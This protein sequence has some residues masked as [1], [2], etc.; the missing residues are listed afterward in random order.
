MPS[1]LSRNIRVSLLSFHDEYEKISAPR[2]VKE[3]RKNLDAYADLEH[4]PDRQQAVA[5]RILDQTNRINESKHIKA[6]TI[7]SLG[8]G[9][10]QAAVL[11]AG[12]LPNFD[13]SAAGVQGPYVTKFVPSA[14]GRTPDEIAQIAKE[15]RLAD[16][17]LGNAGARV[18][19]STSMVGSDKSI[20]G[21]VQEFLPGKAK[22][23]DVHTVAGNLMDK[24]LSPRAKA[25]I[26]R[27]ANAHLVYPVSEMSDAKRKAVVEGLE[28]LRGAGVSPKHVAANGYVYDVR[29]VN[30]GR[31]LQGNPKILDA[32]VHE[33]PTKALTNRSVG[34]KDIDKKKLSRKQRGLD[35]QKA[36]G[37]V[38]QLPTSHIHP[39]VHSSAGNREVLKTVPHYAEHAGK[40]L[41][42]KV[43][44]PVAGLS[45]LTAA[46]ILGHHAY[47]NREKEAALTDTLS[48]L[49]PPHKLNEYGIPEEH[50]LIG[51]A[52]RNRT[53]IL[54]AAGLAGAAVGGTAGYLGGRLFRKDEN[55]NA[56]IYSAATGAVVGGGLASL[57]AHHGILKK[58][59][60]KQS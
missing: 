53:K 51:V 54:G 20:Y 46:G 40:Y 58:I 59:L 14:L 30:V 45:A 33:N 52:R 48:M 37:R 21:E 8:M 9:S 4:A 31:D 47:A 25:K 49:D 34:H 39:A 10:D 24:E 32:G 27:V 36:M 42:K 16:V 56:P 44:L 35:L 17:L 2:W 26:D 1:D 5:Q 22:P 12:R 41:T 55:S 13:P 7:K 28:D 3:Q 11:Q 38:Q 6:R 15:K 19:G 18:Y 43:L 50:S 29:D 60:L 23:G 57:G